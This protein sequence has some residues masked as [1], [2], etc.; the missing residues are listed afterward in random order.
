MVRYD[1][2]FQKMKR[3]H[4]PHFTQYTEIREREG[5]ASMKRILSVAARAFTHHGEKGGGN[6][7]TIFLNEESLSLP[8]REYLAKSCN[9]ESVVV[10]LAN[11]SLPK[12]YFYMPSGEEV[13]YCAH[14]AMGASF[15]ISKTSGGASRVHFITAEG[16]ENTAFIDGN[17]VRLGMKKEHSEMEVDKSIVNLLLHQI[18]LQEDDIIADLPLINSS[19]ARYKTLVPIRMDKLHRASDPHHADSFRDLCDSIQSTGLYIYSPHENGTN[20]FEARQ[21]PRASGYPEDPATGIAAAALSATIHKRI[22][23]MRDFTIFQGRAMGKPS[24]IGVRLCESKIL[25]S[26]DVEIDVEKNLDIE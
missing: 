7:V 9:W 22:S 8:N 15:V 12:L 13:S 20:S 14:A 21:F 2:L 3:C 25:C 10:S 18:N 24:R 1:K 19:V 6:P 11:T 26:G 17:E 5:V 16:V 23:G 4:S